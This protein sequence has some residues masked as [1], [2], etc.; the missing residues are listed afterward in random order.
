LGQKCQQKCQQTKL[1][2]QN[3]RELSDRS[4]ASH[5]GLMPP[6]IT[7]MKNRYRLY[8]RRGGKY[9]A[10][11]EPGSPFEDWIEPEQQLSPLPTT[12]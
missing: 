1:L 9:Y 6:S 10:R 5:T 12:E 2:A 8:R 4:V 11:R 7:P 3:W